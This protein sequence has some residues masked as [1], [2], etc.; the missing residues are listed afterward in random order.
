MILVGSSSKQTVMHISESPSET[1]CLLISSLSILTTPLPSLKKISS[2][3]KI[4]DFPISFFPT[5]AVKSQKSIDT[6]SL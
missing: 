4:L 2:A 6:S 3:S 1:A 5:K